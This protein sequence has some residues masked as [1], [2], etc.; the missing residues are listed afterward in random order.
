MAREEAQRAAEIRAPKQLVMLLFARLSL[1]SLHIPGGIC[2]HHKGRALS[3]KE[4]SLPVLCGLSSYPPSATVACMKILIV[5]TSLEA[6]H[7][8]GDLGTTSE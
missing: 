1:P 5:H 8:R 6:V 3:R 4:T 2:R 7:R